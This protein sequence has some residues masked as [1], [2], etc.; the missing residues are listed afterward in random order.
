MNIEQAEMQAIEIQRQAVGHCHVTRTD[1]HQY[2]AR[3]TACIRGCDNDHVRQAVRHAED[4]IVRVHGDWARDA[5]A[6]G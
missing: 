1:L 2:G 4:E 3:L 5:L 6:G